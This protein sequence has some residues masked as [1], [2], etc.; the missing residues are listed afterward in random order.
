[1][2]DS[3]PEDQKSYAAAID[4]AAMLLYK[5][6]YE[7]NYPGVLVEFPGSP[8][9]RMVDRVRVVRA[10]DE[11]MGFALI[12]ADIPDEQYVY[13]VVSRM[14]R[15]KQ[16][17][18]WLAGNGQRIDAN[19]DPQ[20][21]PEF[22]WIRAR[23]SDYLDATTPGEKHKALRRVHDAAW[24]TGKRRRCSEAGPPAKRLRSTRSI[25]S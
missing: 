16:S 21:H 3:H 20:W 5:S 18:C 22:F 4:V 23:L 7:S 15:N 10:E 11:V 19:S 1:M 17:G 12:D 25:Y 24:P 13:N 8:M 9:T 14:F 2:S 6:G